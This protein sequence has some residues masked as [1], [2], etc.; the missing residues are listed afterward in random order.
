MAEGYGFVVLVKAFL[1]RLVVVGRD[2]ED[3]ISAQGL[4][5]LGRLYNLSCIVA[6]R[7]SQYGN[8]ALGFTNNDFDDHAGA[9]HG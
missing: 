1:S 3:A 4:D 6:S 9:L 8:F 2:R 7:A 5:L